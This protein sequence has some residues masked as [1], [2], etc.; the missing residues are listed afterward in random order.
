MKLIHR[1]IIKEL[2]G[3]FIFGLS[4]IM[5]VF[6]LKFILQHIGKILGKGLSYTTI[7]EFIFLN[8]AWML[9][10]AVPMAVLIAS[11]MA[12]GRLS[13]DNEITI[14]KSTGINL[15]RIITPAII[16]SIILTMGMIWYNDKILPE[17]NHMARKLSY[18]ISRKKPTLQIEE[19]IYLKQDKFNILVEKIERASLAQFNRNTIV[20]SDYPEA[21]ADRLKQITIFDYS[22]TNKQRTVIADHG[23]MKLDAENEMMVFYLFDGEIHEAETRDYVEY[24]RS[25]FGKYVLKVPAPGMSLNKVE[26]LQRGDREMSISMMEAKIE[27]F[28]QQILQTKKNKQQE[29]SNFLMKPEDVKQWLADAKQDTLKPDIGSLAWKNASTRA[30]RKA[31]T[32]VSK[33]HSTLNNQRHFEKQIYRYE[34]EIYKKYSIPFACIVFVLIGAPLGI[35]AKKGSLGVGA[36][37]SIVFFLVYWACLIGGEDLADKQIVEPVFAMWFP[38]IVV[39]SLGVY[40]TYKTVKETTFIQWDRFGGLLKMF[41]R[42]TEKPAAEEDAES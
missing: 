2:T 11:L 35:R 1:Y 36:A 24:R 41:S 27:T 16:W 29:L 30:S 13:A 15:Y 20:N 39:G 10:L 5:L 4:V 9:A 18:S 7:F 28:E 6:I 34:V 14:F 3:P 32:N 17:F 22:N 25:G 12:F 23:Y 21:N 38:N 42:K 19:G 40:L 31:Q 26:E 33:L 8:L 37:F